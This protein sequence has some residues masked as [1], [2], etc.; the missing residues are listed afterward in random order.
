MQKIILILVL[1]TLSLNAYCICGFSS[2]TAWPESKEIKQNAIFMIELGVELEDIMRLLNESYPIYLK[3]GKD[4]IKLKVVNKYF[5]DYFLSQAILKPEK[6][7]EPNRDYEIIIDNFPNFEQVYPKR[8]SKTIT[9]WH[10]TK[11]NDLE[12]PKFKR[13]P[14]E[15]GKTSIMLGCGP[16]NYVHFRYIVESSSPCLVK[17]VLTNIKTRISSTYY[18]TPTED[19]KILVG[20]G[21]CTGAFNFSDNEDYSVT[22]SLI[23]ASGNENIEK[24]QTIKFKSPKYPVD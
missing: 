13:K 7:L 20:H 15:V 23:D 11:G 24:K 9:K 18:L 16:V 1:S 2:I 19:N 12:L 22:F 8:I 14:K 5:G 3:S 6:N 4:T 21:M 10:V 17:T